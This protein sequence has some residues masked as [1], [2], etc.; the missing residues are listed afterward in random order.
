MTPNKPNIFS[1]NNKLT[2][3]RRSFSEYPE[4]GLNLQCSVSKK[5]K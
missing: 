2:R 3:R 1:P 4:I 5:K